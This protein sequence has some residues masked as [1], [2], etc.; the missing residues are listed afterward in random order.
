MRNRR[1]IFKLSVTIIFWGAF[2][3]LFLPFY[4]ELL[5]AGVFALA[6]KPF[7]TRKFHRVKQRRWLHWRPAIALTLSLM[8]VALFIPVTM[9]VYKTYA[10]VRT[11]SRLGVQNTPMYQKILDLKIQAVELANRLLEKMHMQ[12]RVDLPGF[13]EDGVGRSVNFG[14]ATFSAFAS[15]VPN[16]LLSLFI[17]AIA[18]YFFLAEATPLKRIVSRQRV[19]TAGE[20][21]R[22]IKI[23]QSS[24]YNTVVSSVLIAVLQSCLVALGSLALQTGD[25]VVIFTV[26]FFCS[27]VPVIGAGPVAFALGIGQALLGDYPRAVGFL[28]LSVVVG[29]V[30]NLIRPYLVSSGADDLHPVVSLVAII[31]ALII[32]G[33]PGLFLGPVIASVAVRIITTLYDAPKPIITA[34]GKDLAK[35]TT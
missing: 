28:V 33:M 14:L 31:G 15:E 24:C 4:N 18:L 6:M 20:L 29:T 25:M 26:T 19:L 1:A 27:F 10:Y 16:L 11:I 30:D 8:F 22:F 32:F 7:L 13:I 2:I 3:A 35:I 5:M 12:D 17:F 9:I 23:L 34:S 21:R